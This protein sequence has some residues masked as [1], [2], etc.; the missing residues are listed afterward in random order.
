MTVMEVL[1]WGIVIGAASM[2]LAT[3]GGQ[4]EMASEIETLQSRIAFLERQ[5]RS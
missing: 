4:H 1:L 2:W 3:L 5:V